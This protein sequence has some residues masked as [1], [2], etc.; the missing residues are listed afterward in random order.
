[1][2][3]VMNAISTMHGINWRMEA[4]RER[5]PKVSAGGTRFRFISA[6]TTM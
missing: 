4:S 6:Q 3:Q 5:Q 1:M 2:I